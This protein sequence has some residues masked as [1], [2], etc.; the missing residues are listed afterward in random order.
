MKTK[1]IVGTFVGLNFVLFISVIHGA[2]DGDDAQ[3]LQRRFASE[4]KPILQNRCGECHAGSEAN[5]GLNFDA[6]TTLEQILDADRRWSSIV[7]VIKQGSMPPDD[8]EPLTDQERDLLLSWIAGTFDLIDCSNIQPGNVTIRR[9]NRIEYRNSVRDLLGV[10]YEPAENFPGDDVG[11][12]F[13]NIADVL[14][15]PPILMEKYL[16]AAEQISQLAII[17]PES[18]ALEISLSG[19]AFSG[20]NDRT[21]ADHGELKMLATDTASHTVRFPLPGKY[22]VR[23]AAYGDQAGSEPVKMSLLLNGSL[24]ETVDVTSISNQPSDHE[25]SVTMHSAGNHKIQIR[26]EN[27]YYNP[28]AGEDRNLHVISVS[29]QGPVKIPTNIEYLEFP[30]TSD[31]E[32]SAN[33]IREFVSRAFRRTATDSE[34][35]SFQQLFDDARNE[36]QDLFESLRMV[37][38]AVLVSPEFLYR[39]EQ[40]AT[41]EIR[42][43]DDFELATALSFF[44]WSTTPDD[45]LLRLAAAGELSRPETWNRQVERLLQSPRSIALVDNFAAQW[46]NLRLLSESQPDPDRFPAM[47]R[48]L[49][50]DMEIETRMVVADVFR[51]DASVL[52]LLESE[53]TF[54]NARLARHYGL[55]GVN[56]ENGDFL[57]VPLAGTGRSGVLTHGSILTL[58]SNPDRTSPVKRGKWIMENILGEEP[59]PPLADVQPLDEQHQLTGSLRERMEQHR[60][61]PA[62]ASCHTTMD[63]LG[64]ALEQFDAVGRFRLLDDGFEIDSNSE[65]PDG[66]KL[67][68]AIGLAEN[69]RTTYQ[70]KFIRCFTEKLLIYSLGRGLRYYDRCTIDRIMVAASQN[71]YR[72]SAFVTAIANSDTFRKRSGPVQMESDR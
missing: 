24:V 49:L 32:Q 72:L 50:R 66:T 51:R 33:F 22:S 17:N 48:E 53:F 26:F 63:A 38:E 13:D 62:C 7:M 43:L 65:M 25:F 52:E 67:Q 15:L 4:I 46:L 55:N 21:M 5:A 64:F 12:G 42:Q 27:D 36:G 57:Q 71:D 10:D 14:S 16:D 60:S 68:G 70:A 69:L 45:E 19:S 18:P 1:Q 58:T 8:A 47:D 23:I 20:Q 11:H 41:S 31:N 34:R 39:I 37:T 61:D 28:R 44:L 40:P 9:L 3:R 6:F 29:I 2:V 35:N 59:P 30:G 54:V 56:P